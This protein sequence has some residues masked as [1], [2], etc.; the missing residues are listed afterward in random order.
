MFDQP[1]VGT[2]PRG[3]PLF[4]RVALNSGETS[5]RWCILLMACLVVRPSRLSVE[6]HLR[7]HRNGTGS[8]PR[9][10][11]LY[12]HGWHSQWCILTLCSC[13]AIVLISLAS[14]LSMRALPWRDG[15]HGES[16]SKCYTWC[17]FCSHT[18]W[19]WMQWLNLGISSQWQ[20][21]ES[22][23]RWHVCV[24]VVNS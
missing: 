19:T 16:D 18:N 15:R 17:Y 11:P 14:P 2:Q 5:H 8:I 22:Q 24:C 4:Q 10:R 1:S 6:S 23:G 12:E 20:G 9:W 3:F 21:V 13:V 7:Y